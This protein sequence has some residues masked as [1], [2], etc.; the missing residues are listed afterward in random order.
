[1]MRGSVN[2]RLEAKL[3][4]TIIGPTGIRQ[5]VD[6]VIDTGFTGALVLPAA[7]VT[8]LG[9]VRRSGGTAPR[10]SGM[11][12]LAASSFPQSAAKL[13]PGWSFWPATN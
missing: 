9:L 6:V 5:D 12:R 7:T 8:A 1:M 13:S 2:A 10:S 11:V 3:R 4:L